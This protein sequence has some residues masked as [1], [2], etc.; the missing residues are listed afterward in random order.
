M[1]CSSGKQQ[2]ESHFPILYKGKYFFPKNA[3]GVSTEIKG[4]DF[5]K[6]IS[7][8]TA[9]DTEDIT[10]IAIFFKTKVLSITYS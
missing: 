10:N 3:F 6:Y 5:Q 4:N 8:T 9:E 1:K 7:H 2:R